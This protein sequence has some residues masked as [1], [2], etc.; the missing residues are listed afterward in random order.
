[1]VDFVQ[2]N[3]MFQ[4]KMNI[5]DKIRQLLFDNAD[6]DKFITDPN[7]KSTKINPKYLKSI[8]EFNV[9]KKLVS[10]CSDKTRMVSIDLL[11][12]LIDQVK[13]RCSMIG[14]QIKLGDLELDSNEQEIYRDS[15]YELARA[16]PVSVEQ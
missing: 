1:M 4:S 6:P 16:E 2:L 11:T 14:I 13:L 15:L 9:L 5:Q 3:K 12:S 10:Q 7:S 8:N